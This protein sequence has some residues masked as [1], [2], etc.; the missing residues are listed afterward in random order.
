MREAAIDAAAAAIVA[1]I[2]STPRTPRASEIASLIAQAVP[3]EDLLSTASGLTFELHRRRLALH[4]T[5]A[6][7]LRSEGAPG[8]E[9][10]CAKVQHRSQELGELA[11]LAWRRPVESWDDIVM[12]AEVAL[13]YHQDAVRGTIEGL[14]ASCPFER[15]LAELLRAVAT[16]GRCLEQRETWTAQGQE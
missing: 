6:E 10:A 5:I 2:N 4:S 1:I 13:A 7:A 12:R 3:A 15:S 8:Y 14:D 16:M 9:A 11:S